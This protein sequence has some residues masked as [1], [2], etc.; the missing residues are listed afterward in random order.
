MR[1]IQWER[2]QDTS[3]KKK[4]GRG[5]TNERKHAN[6]S[7]Q[8]LSCTSSIASREK[9]YSIL[10]ATSERGMS[11]RIHR[12]R[13][14]AIN[15]QAYRNTAQKSCT[16]T[17]KHATSIC[18]HLE[19]TLMDP[20][21]KRTSATQTRAIIAHLS[22]TWISSLDTTRTVYYQNHQP[23]SLQVMATFANNVRIHPRINVHS[24]DNDRG[25][26]EM[27]NK[28]IQRQQ[29]A[30]DPH[31]RKPNDERKDTRKRQKEST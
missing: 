31:W 16:T 25:C 19:Y 3:S 20:L 12:K 26:D 18:A 10:R 13:A 8:S 29:R 7:H 17:R 9:Q 28:R 14:K 11:L 1:N 2:E 22:A 5:R 24:V 6:E 30:T 4:Q 23:N 27:L 21:T 15:I